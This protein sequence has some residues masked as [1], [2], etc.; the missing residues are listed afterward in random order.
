MSIGLPGAEAA[1]KGI[2]NGFIFIKRNSAIASAK[3]GYL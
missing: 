3:V 1:R 2:I